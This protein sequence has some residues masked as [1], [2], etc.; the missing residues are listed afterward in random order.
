MLPINDVDVIWY[1]PYQDGFV[2]V[3]K[4]T[5]L[6]CGFFCTVRA[7]KEFAHHSACVAKLMPK[8]TK[9]RI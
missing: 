4:A 9:G 3:N 8:S 2:I 5:G 7:V 6:H 1:Q